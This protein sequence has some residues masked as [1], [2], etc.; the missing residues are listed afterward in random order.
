MEVVEN[1]VEMEDAAGREI[2][3][4]RVFD[5]PRE[6]VWEAWTDPKQ[7]ALWWGPKGFTTTIEEM[8][9]RPG[10]VWKQVMH[11]PDGTDY[12]NKSVFLDVVP[13]ERLMYTVR[14]GRAGGPEVQIEKAV[15]FENDEG[16]TRVTMRLTF[17]SAEAR[18][19]NVRDYGSIEGIKQ[20]FEKLAE[21]LAGRLF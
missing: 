6:M 21:Y 18:E 15:I 13:Y 11:G 16:G 4:S 7:V 10:G 3:L 19:Q 9:V 8:D 2:V 1:A 5:A 17:T 12:S 14:G 20:T